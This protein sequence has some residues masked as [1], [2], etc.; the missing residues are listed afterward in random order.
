MVSH[1]APKSREIDLT[2]SAGRFDSR[3]SRFQIAARKRRAWPHS[4]KAFRAGN[5]GFQHLS[6]AFCPGWAS[7]DGKAPLV[8][9]ARRR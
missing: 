1:A 2:S 9:C 4:I 7:V 8:A 3:K 6:P 5:V